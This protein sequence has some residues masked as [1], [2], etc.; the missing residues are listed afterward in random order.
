MGSIW[1]DGRTPGYPTSSTFSGRQAHVHLE[2]A[3]PVGSQADSDPSRIMVHHT[4]SPPTS[5]FE[6]LATAPWVTPTPRVPLLLGA[7]ERDHAAGASNHAGRAALADR[8]PCRFGQFAALGSRR[9]LEVGEC[10]PRRST[11]TKLVRRD[12]AAYGLTPS[13]DVVAPVPPGGRS[14]GGSPDAGFPHQAP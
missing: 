10:G 9:E 7:T 5:S 14:V 13:L 12:G 2:V 11:P 4:A 1:L 8:G 6:R 3:P